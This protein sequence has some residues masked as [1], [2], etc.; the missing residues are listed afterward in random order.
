MANMSDFKAASEKAGYKDYNQFAQTLGYQSSPVAGS[1][2]QPI[3]AYMG[4]L[5][6]NFSKL[7]QQQ[8]QQ[9]GMSSSQFSNQ[10]PQSQYNFGQQPEQYNRSYDSTADIQAYAQ[11]QS[12]ALEAKLRGQADRQLAAINES[13]AKV[14]PRFDEARQMTSSDAAIAERNF[15]RFLADRGISNTGATGSQIQA[16]LMNQQGLQGAMGSLNSQQEEMT[17]DYDFQKFDA[18]KAFNNSL[19]SGLTDINLSAMQEQIRSKEQQDENKYQ[20]YRDQMLDFYKNAELQFN[21]DTTTA[22]LAEANA[23]MDSIL[24]DR[25]FDNEQFNY[26]KGQDEI[27]NQRE[28]RRLDINVDQFM[29]DMAL[30]QTEADRVE[31]QRQ[32]E[33]EFQS[34]REMGYVFP[35]D[36]MMQEYDVNKVTPYSGDYQ[37]EINRREQLVKS[38]QMTYQESMIPEL[39]AARLDKL[40]SSPSLLRQYG[41]EYRTTDS[42]TAEKQQLGLDISNEI[43]KINLEALPEKQRLEFEQI[44]QL[45]ESGQLEIVEQEI[46]NSFLPEELKTDILAVKTQMEVSRGQ[47]AVSQGQLGVAQG[48]LSLSQQKEGRM[49]S[50]AA[51]GLALD[52]QKMQLAAK[53]LQARVK[54]SEYGDVTSS[55]LVGNI[56]DHFGY[57]DGDGRI[58]MEPESYVQAND[59]IDNLQASDY[60]SPSV[61]NGVKAQMAQ[62]KVSGGSN[63]SAI[64]GGH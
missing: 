40:R 16:N 48:N 30:R 54:Q 25:G 34:N 23:R 10:L 2:V 8:N 20:S 50:N 59:Y 42:R 63:N 5:Q 17:K 29:Q 3:G 36:K 39:E 28:D 62:F 12:D 45:L 21:A 14:Q 53:E 43:N 15:Q 46:R 41:D 7:P 33:N 64:G 35:V 61:V 22:G 57:M 9:Q 51:Q 31:R 18:E 38:G 1:N 19:A 13:I 56:A 27:G 49:A 60:V 55:I 37:A 11:A 44:R 58:R 26:G 32:F 24:Y 4:A 6:D 47:L 52:Q